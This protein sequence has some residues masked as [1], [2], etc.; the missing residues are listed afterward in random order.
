MRQRRP[1]DQHFCRGNGNHNSHD[2]KYNLQAAVWLPEAARRLL[3]RGRPGARAEGGR[4]RRLL[5]GQCGP[6]HAEHVRRDGRRRGQACQRAVRRDRR[7]GGQQQQRSGRA[8][9]GEGG[10][11]E[12]RR[13]GQEEAAGRHQEGRRSESRAAAGASRDGRSGGAGSGGAGGGGEERRGGAWAAH[14]DCEAV[15]AV[16]HHRL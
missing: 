3:P 1:T 8:W 4:C 12:R 2:A 11:A 15:G 9:R 5:S 16:P 14:G 13:G 10:E 7:G 6:V